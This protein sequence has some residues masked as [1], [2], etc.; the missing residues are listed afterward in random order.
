MNKRNS[1]MELLR[2]VAMVMII[3][4]HIFANSINNQLTNIGPNSNE[5]YCQPYFSKKIVYAGCCFTNGTGWKYN[6]YY[7]FW[8]FFGS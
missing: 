7:Y 3:V 8:I 2:I 6:F 4:F 5:W 1:N